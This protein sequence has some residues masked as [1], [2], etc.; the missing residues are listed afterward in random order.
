MNKNSSRAWVYFLLCIVF[1][2]C[3]TVVLFLRRNSTPVLVHIES[4]RRTDVELCGDYNKVAT[5][6]TILNP[7]RSRLQEHLAEEFLQ[8]V[9]VGRCSSATSDQLCEYVKEGHTIPTTNWRLVTRLDDAG[10]VILLY[11][12][13]GNS[14][15]LT[16]HGGCAVARVEAK[17]NS[18][19]WK[20][21]GFGVTYGPFRPRS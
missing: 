12:L 6:T 20:I 15:I 18:D 11:R 17:Q 10:T 2:I 7:F 16:T 19:V 5:G 9:S 1:V 13:K 14:E 21:V 4:L 3:A 8:A